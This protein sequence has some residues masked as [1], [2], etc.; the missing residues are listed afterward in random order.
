MGIPRLD[1]A[2]VAYYVEKLNQLRPDSE[3]RWGALRP[4]SLVR[5]L[6]TAVEMSLGEHAELAR[7]PIPLVAPLLCWL[8]F[9]VFTKWPGGKIKAP[10]AFTPEPEG[11]LDEEREALIGLL[12]AFV[13]ESALHPERREA[14]IVFGRLTL[15]Y[16]ERVHAVHFCHHFRQFG[17]V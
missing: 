7:E 8:S 17:L 3:R 10:D 5:H 12:E 11:T 14:S 16:Y 4:A 2:H 15:R 13:K 1:K 6:R 9:D